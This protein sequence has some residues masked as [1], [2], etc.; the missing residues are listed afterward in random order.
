MFSNI[1]WDKMLV[2]L[3]AAL[4]VLGP[5][6]LPGALHQCLQFLHRAR[7]YASGATEALREEL[8]PTFGEFRP[9]LDDV[10]Q[11]F[12]HSGRPPDSAPRVV[13]TAPSDE[14][15]TG[16]AG[17]HD[18]QTETTAPASG[19]TRRK[20]HRHEAGALASPGLGA[21][22]RERD[23]RRDPPIGWP[24]RPRTVPSRL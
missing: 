17:G 19:D 12:P 22:P 7:D 24:R 16:I 18:P 15:E 10:G 3:V 8:R 6:R 4:V 1:G 13:F 14:D 2:L 20:R 11:M 21:E 23:F 9:A 5:E